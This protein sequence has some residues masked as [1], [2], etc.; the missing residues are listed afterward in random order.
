LLTCTAP[1]RGAS[2][3]SGKAFGARNDTSN[4]ELVDYQSLKGS[5]MAIPTSVLGSLPRSSQ[6][7]DQFNDYENVYTN[8]A[9]LEVL[10][11]AAKEIILKQESLGLDIVNDGEVQRSGYFSVFYDTFDGYM[12]TGIGE[13]TI[14]G[15]GRYWDHH[16]RQAYHVW[17]RPRAWATHPAWLKYG[18]V[19]VDKLARR[20]VADSVFHHEVRVMKRHASKPIKLTIPSPYQIMRRS[21][22][23]I[24][25][26]DAYP[27]QEEYLGDIVKHYTPII[28][29][30]EH[31]GVDVIQFDDD[32]ITLLLDSRMRGYLDLEREI[33][34]CTI[35]LNALFSQMHTAQSAVHICRAIVHKHIPWSEADF[36]AK[37]FE[38]L[39]CDQFSVALNDTAEDLLPFEHFPTDAGLL[40][41][42]IY[43]NDFAL[44]TLQTM[45]HRLESILEYVPLNN[46]I[47]TPNCGFSPYARVKEGLTLVWNKLEQL[48][49]FARVIET[50]GL[51]EEAIVR[52]DKE[53]APLRKRHERRLPNDET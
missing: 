10:E 44:E 4:Q 48:V 8:P 32:R 31:L 34:L 27:T 45:F 28:K 39:R 3:A 47:L 7:L 9:A 12:P 20:D 46:I 37:L 15:D 17:E 1:Q 18:A 19:V 2:V 24:F 26:R 42:I 14:L 23:P 5:A 51:S 52:A 43:S 22:H 49:R 21:W 11:A 35:S 25:S 16:R 38:R 50:S 53:S 6:V 29:E 36:L 33:D 41:G 30:C 13:P 40:F